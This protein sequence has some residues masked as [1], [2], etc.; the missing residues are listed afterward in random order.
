MKTLIYP[1]QSFQ[2]S[3]ANP[4]NRAALPLFFALAFLPSILHL[5]LFN[6]PV[7]NPLVALGPV[8]A[9]F[10]LTGGLRGMRVNFTLACALI[11]TV[12]W[13]V[14]WLMLADGNCCATTCL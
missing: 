3:F 11:T 8:A 14:N 12:L 6:L 7:T 10:W 5:A 2:N 4:L 13:A 9:G 1:V